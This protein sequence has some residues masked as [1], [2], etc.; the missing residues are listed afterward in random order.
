[1]TQHI[2]SPPKLYMHNIVLSEILIYQANYQNKQV[3]RKPS[4]NRC[5]RSLTPAVRSFNLVLIRSDPFT[6][7]NA[8]YCVILS[9]DGNQSVTFVK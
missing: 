2:H 9:K 4:Q 1:M 7:T 5:L 6:H 8:E 3:K